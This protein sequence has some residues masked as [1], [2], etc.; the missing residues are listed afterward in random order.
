[1]DKQ[2]AIG[3]TLADKQI[4][5]VW[6]HS[7]FHTIPYQSKWYDNK[8]MIFSVH[9]THSFYFKFH[10]L[11]TQQQ[12]KKH[13]RFWQLVVYVA[14][15]DNKVDF[16]LRQISPP[17]FICLRR[18]AL[19]LKHCLNAF[20]YTKD[21]IEYVFSFLDFS[22][23]SIFIFQLTEYCKTSTLFSSLRSRSFPRLSGCIG[24]GLLY[25]SNAHVNHEY[26]LKINRDTAI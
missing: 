26:S 24:K 17:L 9:N 6:I 22:I 20:L 10:S 8:Q 14:K 7:E 18:D 3:V 2:L 25:P 4:L 16:R 19:C 15:T 5:A 12:L 11:T 13:F 1:M 23:H 21:P